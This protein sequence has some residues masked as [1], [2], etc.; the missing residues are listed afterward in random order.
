MQ[1]SRVSL[2]PVV[3]NFYR[4]ATFGLLL[5]M[6][7]VSQL[8]AQDYIPATRAFDAPGCSDI[9]LGGIDIDFGLGTVT[10]PSPQRTNPEWK[11]IVLDSSKP[12]HLQPPTTLEGFVAP[13]PA[14][15]T[16]KAQST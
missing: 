3:R 1:G 14:D 2:L 9:D 10:V 13:Q 7:G 5:A 4:I 8:S 6:G 12:P 15:K 16:S 11:A